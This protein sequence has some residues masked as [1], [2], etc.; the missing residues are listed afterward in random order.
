M[1]AIMQEA[2]FE[3]RSRLFPLP[4]QSLPKNECLSQPKSGLRNPYN[5]L[6][7]DLATTHLQHS[8]VS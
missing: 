4:D 8:H 3:V 1:Y 5:R 6:G 7:A 2:Q